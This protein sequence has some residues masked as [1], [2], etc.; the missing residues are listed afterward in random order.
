MSAMRPTAAREVRYV[1]FKEDYFGFIQLH[2]YRFF[3]RL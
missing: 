1:N 3:Y 2:D